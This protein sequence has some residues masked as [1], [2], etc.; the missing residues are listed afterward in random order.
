MDA[1]HPSAS[2]CP[3]HYLS[4]AASQYCNYLQGI[5]M[6]SIEISTMTAW[7]KAG[8]IWE[9]CRGDENIYFLDQFDNQ[10]YCK[11]L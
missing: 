10:F 2:L 1:P 3:G 4:A 8:T 6:K 7:L 5:E 9:E 11:C